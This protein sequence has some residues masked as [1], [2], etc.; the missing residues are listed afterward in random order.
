LK[1]ELF[2]RAEDRRQPGVV[3]GILKLRYNTLQPKAYAVLHDDEQGW[4]VGFLYTGKD[5][6]KLTIVE[7]ASYLLGR[8][9]IMKDDGTEIH[10]AHKQAIL[11]MFEK[12]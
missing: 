4:S 12:L 5:S 9:V 1:W 6:V 7:G 2:D 10:I 11:S 3:A 8:A